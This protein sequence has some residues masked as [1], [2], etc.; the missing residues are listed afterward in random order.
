MLLATAVLLGRVDRGTERPPRPRRFGR[1]R[2]VD[3]VVPVVIGFWTLVAPATDDDG[4]YAAMARNARISG[5]VGNYYQLYDQNFTPFTWFY[6]V[7]GWWQGVV[8]DAPVLQR[9]LAVAFGLLTWVLL[10]RFAA[11]AMAEV[12]PDRPGVRSA[13]HVDAGGGV[14]G[15]V[16]AAGHGGAARGRGVRVRRR[17]DARGAGG[18]APRA[19]GRRVAGVRPG[20]A[21][22]RRAPHR[23]HAARPAAGR[24]TAALA[25]GR[26]ARRPRRPPRCGRSRW[27]RA[28]WS[29]RCWR[30]S[31]AACAT[32]SAASG[33][34]CRSRPRRAG[35]RRSSAT[36]SCWA[37]S[38]W[39]TTPSGRRCCCA[40]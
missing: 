27:C 16:A 22:L 32:S 24:A 40:W 29:R 9:L 36:P 34:S 18:V 4:Y 17:G 11:D 25:A 10:R 31:T 15:L 13:C 37:R 26:G 1:P 33:S 6:Y 23:V 30:S 7:L 2:I 28:A 19:A 12:A 21:G 35:P 3:A 8:G 20:R 38:R 5:E 39:A 14:P